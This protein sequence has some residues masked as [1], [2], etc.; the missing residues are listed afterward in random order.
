MEQNQIQKL[1]NDLVESPTTGVVHNIYSDLTANNVAIQPELVRMHNDA[2]ASPDDR[3]KESRT[4]AAF[5]T[6]LRQQGARPNGGRRKGTK[7]RKSL[8]K[9][10]TRRR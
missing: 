6:F 10:T 3:V 2:M 7:K 5:K 8:R 9:R 1:Y 4:V